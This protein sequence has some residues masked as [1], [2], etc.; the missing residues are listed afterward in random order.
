MF[1]LGLIHVLSM[2][3]KNYTLMLLA[4]LDL[5]GC[6]TANVISCLQDFLETYS[7]TTGV[8]SIIVGKG[9]HSTSGS[10]LGPLVKQYLTTHQ[11]SWRYAKLM[12]GGQGVL[13]VNV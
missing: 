1:C 10:V 9:N 7:Q 12:D 8:V 2:K 4:E 11:Y 3:Q 6:T 5:H 13:L